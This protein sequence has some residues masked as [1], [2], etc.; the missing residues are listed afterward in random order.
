MKYEAELEYISNEQYE[1]PSHLQEF[2]IDA[3]DMNEAIKKLRDR[4]GIHMSD[5]DDYF[6]GDT[7]N[8]DHHVE[9]SFGDSHT[10]QDVRY[11]VALIE[12]E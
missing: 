1:I 4:L 5:K 10:G 3:C 2:E 8:Y 11:S 9:I 7:V 6:I 12:E